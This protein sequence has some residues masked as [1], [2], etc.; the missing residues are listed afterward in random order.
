MN[1]QSKFKIHSFELGPMNNFVY[2]VEDTSSKRA[3]VVDPAWDIQKIF[4]L[5]ENR[6][7]TITDVLLT[8]SHSDHVNG[9]SDVLDKFDA[10][11]HLS[12]AESEF[13]GVQLAKPFLHYG[14]DT[15]Q[16]G[17]TEIE[18][19]H[20]PGH[21]PG[22]ACYK[23]E[24]ELITGDTMFVFGCGRCDLS[25]GDPELMFNTLR[26]MKNVLPSSTV[27][28]PGHN[29]SAT[30]TATM[31]DQVAGNPFMHFDNLD[32]FTKFRMHTH[33]RIRSTPYQPVTAE[34]VDKIL[35]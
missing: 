17:K 14:G 12:Q 19:L 24:N 35:K 27:I 29:Y 30:P 2:L 23:I 15:I 7:A 25:G 3:A 5:A 33:S 34:Q 18:M 16:L 21:T 8:H 9:V 1:A 10:Q 22:S 4:D 20:T 31:E 11:L 32:D 28:H 6:G 13:W 26:H